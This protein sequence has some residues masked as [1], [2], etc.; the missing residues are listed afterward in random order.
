MQEE[1]G[2]EAKRLLD[3]PDEVLE[4]IFHDLGEVRPIEMLGA[5]CRRLYA[6]ARDDRLWRT[7][8]GR[9]W[10][11][12]Y[13]KGVSGLGWH[14][15]A[16]P[17]DPWSPEIVA[18]WDTLLPL[19]EPVLALRQALGIETKKALLWPQC[20]HD[21]LAPAPFS[22][23]PSAGAS[24]HWL[25]V[26]HSNRD[27]LK[28]TSAPCFIP[29]AEPR[30]VPFE[31]ISDDWHVAYCGETDSEGRPHGYGVQM[32]CTQDA[33]AMQWIECAWEKGHP[34]GWRVKV[35]S[36]ALVCTMSDYDARDSLL[37]YTIVRES[38][39]RWWGTMR[40]GGMSG[41]CAYMSR[42]ICWSGT[43]C[44][45]RTLVGTVVIPDG[46]T[47][48]R[49]CDAE[50]RSQGENVVRYSNGDVA[51]TNCEDDRVCGDLA[52]ICSPSCPD[53]AFAARRLCVAGCGST[54]VQVDPVCACTVYWPDP[55]DATDDARLFRQYV[56]SG[57]V[58]WHPLARQT[59]LQHI[60][61]EPSSSS[62]PWSHAAV[63]PFS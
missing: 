51:I 45:D 6:I 54:A 46:R 13:E 36:H 60:V 39:A 5:T 20:P 59:A 44:D 4:Q 32:C 26:A 49:V 55:S 53:P 27:P 24:W 56:Q 40:H 63:T 2:S 21:P 23:M 22:H 9:L 58:G 52:F 57:L 33:H 16:H 35:T 38:D 42:G 14:E 25:V 1:K 48:A 11:H 31:Q 28:R 29:V 10:G 62:P 34:V 18:F 37:T 50:G 12:V 17:D 61:S 30:D 3:L 41:P 47:I 15:G 8:F 7:V 43:V 19:Y